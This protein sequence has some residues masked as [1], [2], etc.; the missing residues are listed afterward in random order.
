V[1][2]YTSQRAQERA[3]AG[4]LRDGDFVGDPTALERI[5][6]L[7]ADPDNLLG[8]IRSGTDLA[9]IDPRPLR[10]AVPG[11]FPEGLTLLAGAPKR[12]KS[13][14][15][16]DSCLA[17]ALG[18]K[19]LGA[20]AVLQGRSFYLA[21]EDSDRRLQS[22]AQHLLGKEPIP[23]AFEYATRLPDPGRLIELLRTYCRAHADVRLLVIDT[24]ARIRPPQPRHRGAYDW[25]YAVGSKLKEVA[26]EFHVALVVVTH[27][28]QM[29]AA[30]FVEAVSGTSGLTGAADTIVVLDRVRG[31][32]DGRLKVTGRDVQEAEYA[33][34]MVGGAWMLLDRPP[35]D[36]ALGDR[37]TAILELARQRP[38]GVRAADVAAAVGIDDAQARAYLS[39]LREAE[40][41]DQPS[42]GLYVL[43]PVTSI[44]SV[45]FLHSKET[46]ATDE[47]EIQTGPS[48]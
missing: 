7:E 31:Q 6:A 13:W 16:L 39:R 3:T 19:A 17:V 14:L 36:P 33:L 40:R 34:R 15:A 29:A 24:L 11:V 41:L 45:A 42:R 4:R 46:H 43:P 10:Y 35:V 1:T 32:D 37:S 12:G 9:G 8:C 28:R 20:V 5:R 21:L 2:S 27:T 26:D 23:A 22:R 25:D 47:T 48:A 44:A 38:E 18:G 30:D